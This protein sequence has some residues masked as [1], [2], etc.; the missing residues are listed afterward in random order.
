MKI[1]RKQFIL[2]YFILMNL[3]LFAFFI[4]ILGYDKGYNIIHWCLFSG[5]MCILT[6]M[7]YIHYKILDKILIPEL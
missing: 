1:K 6:S 3:N 5:I 7:E 4:C 2:Y